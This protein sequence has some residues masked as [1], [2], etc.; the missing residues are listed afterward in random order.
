MTIEY[1]SGSG[2]AVTLDAVAADLWQRLVSIFLVDRD[3]RRP[4]L[5]GVERMQTDPRWRNNVL[6]FEYFHGD[7]GAGLGAS[8]QA[9]WSRTGGRCDPASPSGIPDGVGG[10]SAA[11]VTNGD[12]MTLKIVPGRHDPLGATS[13]LG[14]TNFAVASGGDAVTLCLFDSGGAESQLP[15]PDRDGDIWHGLVPGVGPGQAYGY[16][17]SGP[18]DPA[19]GL[20][21]NPAK[22]LLDPYARAI[23]GDVRF[24][25]EVLGHAVENSSAPSALDSAGHVPRSLVSPPAPTTSVPDRSTRSPTPSFTRFTFVDSPHAT[26]AYLRSCA[27][28]TPGLAH[29]AALRT[30]CRASA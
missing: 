1:P 10:R 28:P 3:G 25:P 18:F 7:N 4:C 8:H 30:P 16:R 22:L 2:T 23:D 27:A 5:G 14:G 6:F 9:G 17:V 29:E 12:V 11:G 13:E 15:L 19:R 20:R 26:R 24:G 21:Y